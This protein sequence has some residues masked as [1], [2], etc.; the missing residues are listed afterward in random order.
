MR[1]MLILAGVLVV[2]LAAGRSAAPDDP[3]IPDPGAQRRIEADLRF[4]ADD[5]LEGRAT[6]SRGLDVAALYLASQLRAAGWEPG[7][8]DSYFQAHELAT[9]VPAKARYR[10]ALNGVALEPDEY[11]FIPIAFDAR[12]GTVRYDLVFSG[13]GVFLPEKGVDDYAGLD[14]AGKAV[15]AM[16]GAPWPLDPTA[17]HSPDRLLGK[18]VSATVRGARM[19]VYVSEEFASAAVPPPS[20]EAAFWRH[21][22]TGAMASLPELGDRPAMAAGPALVIT[23]AAFDRTLASAVGGSYAEVQRRLREPG[24]T[25]RQIPATIELAVDTKPERGRASNVVAILRGTDPS[26]RDDWVV[27]SAHFD[28][29]GR[30]DVPAGQDGIF[31]G[32]D[33]NAS[34]TAAVLEVA[35][36]LAAGPRPRRSVLA[37]LT[38]GEDMGLLGS[39]HY[40]LHPL[41]P[42]KQVVVDV[43]VDMVGRSAGSVIALAPG[44]D[45]LFERAVAVGRQQGLEVQPDKTPLLRLAY[46][47]DSYHFARFGVPV[48]SFFTDLHADY[49]GPGDE[50]DKIHYAELTRIVDVIE[51]LAAHYAEGAARPAY[52][53]PS[54][55]LT[56]PDDVPSGPVARP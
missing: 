36:R 32:A 41:V 11:I 17:L 14:V 1:S 13:H 10:V 40:A 8:G 49:H 53:R 20:V 47:L 55:F 16:L 27:L 33:D 28:H 37:L 44:S 3:A 54:W 12:R 34:G 51:G 31:N 39:A 19:F 7:A 21:V 23:P 15:L 4:L 29:V 30:T 9:I 24:R 42:W 46:F 38:A 48:V 26:F 6:P 18:S 56:P 50:A 22:A 25:T 5:L 52:G 43:N 35:R 2:G 45:A